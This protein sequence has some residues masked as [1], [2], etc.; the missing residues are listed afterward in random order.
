MNVGRV[1]T[2]IITRQKSTTVLEIGGYVGFSAILFGNELRKSGGQSKYLSLELNPS[3]AYVA[4]ELIALAGLDQTVEIIEGPCR[5]SLRKLRQ[6]GG[7][8]FDITFI[9]HA[10][11]LYLMN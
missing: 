1:V 6:Q 3:F 7:E 4:R 9:D 5:D 8:A 11:V 2:D 10:K